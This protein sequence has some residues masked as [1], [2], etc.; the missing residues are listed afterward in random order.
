MRILVL[1]QYYPP[2]SANTARLLGDWLEELALA[3]DVRIIAGRPS[4]DVTRAAGPQRVKVTR[5][6]SL[7]LGRGTLL[8]RVLTY[9]SYLLLA[10]ARSLVGRRPD[11][12]VALTDPPI[13]GAIGALAAARHRRPLVLV[14]HDVHPDSA[15]A[16]GLVKEG[17]AVKLWRAI[18]RFAR[19]R[20]DTIVVVGRDMLR[21]FEE[22][23]VPPHKLVYVPTWATGDRLDPVARDALRALHGWTER[24]IVMHAGNMGLAQNLALIPDVAARLREHPAIRLVLLGDGPARPALAAA[25]R[26]RGLPNVDFLAAV[27]HAEAQA[28]M[29]AADLHLV[30]L[31]PGLGGCAA[32][33]KTY[34]VMAA[35]RPFVAAVDE[36]SEPQLIA[37]EF[38]CGM[39]VPAG[40]AGALANAILRMRAGPL[41]AMGDRARAG[42]ESS[43]TRERCVR[44]LAAVLERTTE[45]DRWPGRQPLR[46]SDTAPP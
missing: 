36:G 35:G 17:A 4:Y 27:P 3:H 23:G 8:A 11:V 32:P 5:V 45:R 33:S 44:Q 41:Q 1:N 39:S 25:I 43:F 18:N 13:V 6:P 19:S 22:Q 29:S 2:D 16:M 46:W 42:Y 12:V 28:L 40:D 24:F 20:A 15:L 14:S 38:G 31:I 30:S 10:A 26:D 7:G 21:R 34:G 9:L 37:D